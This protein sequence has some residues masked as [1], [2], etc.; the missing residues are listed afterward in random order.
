MKEFNT[1]TTCIKEEHYMVDTRKK[2]AKIEQMIAKGMYFT[3]NR[4]RQYGKTTTMS[5][6][7]LTLQDKYIIIP[8]SIEGF[9]EEPYKSEQKFAKT[10]LEMIAKRVI[11]QDKEISDYIRSFKEIKDMDDL[12]NSITKICNKAKKEIVLMIDEV[13]K[14]SSNIIFLDFLAMLR[15]KYNSR[16]NGLDKTFKSVILAGVHD[17]KSL[18]MH[19]KERRILTEDE[20]KLVD[21]TTYNSPWNVAEDF[22]IDMSF[23]SQEIATMLIEYEEENKTGMNIGEI[24]DEIYRYTNGYPFLVSKVCKVIA[25]DLDNV[26][27]WG[28]QGIERAIKIILKENNTLF[29]S[30][31]KN[32]ENDSKL[33]EMVYDILIDGIEYS[34]VQTDNVISKAAMYGIIKE[35]ENAKVQI[36]NKIFELLLY[37]HMS[38]KKEREN[39]RIKRYDSTSQFINK[40]GNIDM[41]AILD[42]FQELMREEYRKETE[43][44][45]EKE[46]RMIFLAFIKPI[47]NGTGFY[48]VE[49]ETR[50]N[51]RIDI[52][53]TYN[54]KRYIIELKKWYG[55]AREEKGYNQLAEYIEIKNMDEGYMVMFDFNKKK[56]YKNEWIEVEGKRIYEIV[57]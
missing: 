28:I 42:K 50:T 10:F 43:K 15:D 5:R 22:K 40:E 3:I 18:K 6:L 8:G 49:V 24:A 44:F 1:T 9:G 46:G 37:N 48:D 47:I 34:Y 27:K 19:I 26:G 23:N 2:L 39:K 12:S 30:L 41:V 14:A 51:K 21:K 33:N 29:D 54:Q 20:A 25:E 4:A 36:H 13:D 52:I 32:I 16:K 53:I 7:F 56:R 35:S 17:V 57:V 11:T 55:K 38:I 45:K 31:I